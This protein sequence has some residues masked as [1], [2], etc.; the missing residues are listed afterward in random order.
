LKLKLEAKTMTPNLKGRA[1]GLGELSRLYVADTSGCVTPGP[2]REV[3]PGNEHTG[4]YE[5]PTHVTSV[6]YR[7][8]VDLALRRLRPL[9]TV[10]AATG[11]EG[12]REEGTR[13]KR[14][15]GGR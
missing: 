2:G 8:E 4:T 12:G 9:A 3:P 15:R 13:Y 1:Q 10:T 6:R 5:V 14:R 11:R 7:S